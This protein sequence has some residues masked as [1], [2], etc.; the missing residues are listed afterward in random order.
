MI[1]MGMGNDGTVDRSPRIDVEI[2]IGA[3]KSGF[4]YSEQFAHN[5]VLHD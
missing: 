5:P 1:G 3:I 4:R 2:P